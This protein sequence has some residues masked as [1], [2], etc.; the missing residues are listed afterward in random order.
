MTEKNLELF[1]QP[2][3]LAL[4]EDELER[5]AVLAERR[6]EAVRTIE[7]A[8]LRMTNHHDW[9]DM[10]GRPYLTATGAEKLGALFGISITDLQ[11]EEV[12]RE[13]DKGRWIEFVARAKF[14]MGSRQIEAIG[15]ASSRSKFFGW[16]KG[17]LKPIEEV[18]L[19]SI[20]KAAISNCKRNGILTLLGLRSPTYEDLKAAGVDVSRIARVEFQK[21][22]GRER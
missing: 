18:D 2:T 15:T 21:K 19:P 5:L 1:D 13:D 20:R 7:R 10:A 14:S 17:E 11:V 4:P 8:A 3:E 12:T 16:A 6:V 22:G 9:V